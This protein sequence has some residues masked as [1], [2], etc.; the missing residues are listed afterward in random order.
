MFTDYR[1]GGILEWGSNKMN[2]ES[3]VV[4]MT[5]KSEEELSDTILVKAK[6]VQEIVQ[7]IETKLA[8]AS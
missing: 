6:R 4:E 2:Q 5:K 8:K 3:P 1:K 7:Q